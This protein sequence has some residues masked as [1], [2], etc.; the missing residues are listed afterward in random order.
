[1]NV[2]ARHVALLVAA[3]A[4][5][6]V[7]CAVS[8]RHDESVRRDVDRKLEGIKNDLDARFPSGTSKAEVLAFMQSRFPQA[9]GGMEDCGGNSCHL[10]FLDTEPSGVWYCGPIDVGVT[11]EFRDEALAGVRLLSRANDCL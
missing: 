5:G 7:G 4:T 6:Y 3:V 10:F 2:R 11:I 9:Y 8:R 1:M